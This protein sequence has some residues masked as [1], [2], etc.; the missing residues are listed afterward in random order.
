M[1]NC[2]WYSNIKISKYNW[3]KWVDNTEMLGK[4]NWKQDGHLI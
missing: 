1:N 4:C 2:N 3:K